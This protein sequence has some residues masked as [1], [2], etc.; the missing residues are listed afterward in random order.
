MVAK[1][2]TCAKSP[3]GAH[4]RIVTTITMGTD[5]SRCKYC[6]DV[7]THPATQYRQDVHWVGPVAAAP[8]PKGFHWGM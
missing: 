1:S 3:T 4:H 7:Q 5:E 2:V 6:G 8:P